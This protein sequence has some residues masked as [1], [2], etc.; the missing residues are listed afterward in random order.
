MHGHWLRC[1]LAVALLGLSIASCA[2]G[3]IVTTGGEGSGST[4]TVPATSDGGTVVGQAD[5]GIPVHCGNGVCEGTEGEDCT[6]CPGDC[7]CTGGLACAAGVCRPPGEDGS[8]DASSVTTQHDGGTAADGGAQHDAGTV[9]GHLSDWSQDGTDMLPL[10][11]ENHIARVD[12]S[13]LP[14]ESRSS[15]WVNAVATHGGGTGYLKAYMLVYI[16]YVGTGVPM[17]M[18]SFDR[19]TDSR[20]SDHVPYALP[21]DYMPELTSSDSKMFTINRDT[22]VVYEMSYVDNCMSGEPCTHPMGR[23]PDGT[24]V[25]GGGAVYSLSDLGVHFPPRKSGVLVSGMQQIPLML[26]RADIASGSLDHAVAVAYYAP[27]NTNSSTDYMW[28]ASAT[29]Y[30]SSYPA[31]FPKHGARVRL[32]AGY[33]ISGFSHNNQILLQGLK[34]YGGFFTITSGGDGMRII[35][36]KESLSSDDNNQL[37]AAGNALLTQ[38]EFVDESSLMISPTSYESR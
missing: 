3:E 29:A 33:D 15:T 24:Y 14:T 35:A 20:P 8:V 30:V 7:A 27:G 32:K 2:P 34:T 19:E 26:S 22:R 13:S 6:S 10:L 9:T 11:P 16:Q 17:Q 18:F 23:Y 4:A 12:I 36:E 25:A 31:N 5:A 21:I 28:P 38:F 1:C 37:M